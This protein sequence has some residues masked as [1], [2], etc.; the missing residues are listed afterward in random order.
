MMRPFKSQRGRSR[1]WH[2]GM[3][4]TGAVALALTAAACTSSGAQS[5]SGNTPVNG[6]T[7]VF[8]LAPSTAANYIFPYISANC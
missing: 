7:A 2:C 5:S 6:G 8:A 1:S 3:L 4:V